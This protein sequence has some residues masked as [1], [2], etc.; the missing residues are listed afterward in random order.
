MDKAHFDKVFS[1]FIQQGKEKV[2]P[3]TFFQILVEIEREHIERTIELQ[4]RIVEG[5]LRFDPSSEI[6]V[7]DNEIILGD[8]R[9]VIK[10][11]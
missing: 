4:A 6:S 2:T 1:A 7:Q 3:K 5:Q 10:M 9:I 8:Q 11:P